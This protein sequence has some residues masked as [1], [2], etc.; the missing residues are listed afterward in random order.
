M[1]QNENRFLDDIQEYIG[2]DIP[3]KIKPSMEIVDNS[4][5]EFE[6]KMNTRPKLKKQKGQSLA[7]KL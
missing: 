4:K 6:D 5:V 1:T 3:L 7:K 2:K